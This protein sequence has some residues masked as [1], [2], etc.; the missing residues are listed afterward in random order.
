MP[1]PLSFVAPHSV[2]FAKLQVYPLTIPRMNTRRLT[3]KHRSL[4]IV[5]SAHHLHDLL[6]HSKSLPDTHFPMLLLR[7]PCLLADMELA[8]SSGPLRVF[9]IQQHSITFDFT[10][11]PSIFPKAPVLLLH[12]SQTPAALSLAPSTCHLKILPT[13]ISIIA[14]LCTLAASMPLASL[15]AAKS[16]TG[17]CYLAC[18]C[19]PS[20]PMSYGPSRDSVSLRFQLR[21]SVHP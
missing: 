8:P 12:F 17:F 9:I 5:P 2:C 16:S 6:V 11:L 13:V 10:P 21:V 4:M 14:C 7:L 20:V 3:Q 15:S 18:H 19:L 1:A